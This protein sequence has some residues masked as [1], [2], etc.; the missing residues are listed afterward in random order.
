MTWLRYWVVL[1]AVHM[2]E[3]V[4]DPL[5]DFPW[6]SP[7]QM[8]LPCLVHGP[9]SEQW[10]QSDFH[11]DHLPTVQEASPEDR[12]AGVADGGNVATKSGQIHARGTNYEKQV[13]IMR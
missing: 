12:R 7:C 2:V 3:L 9:N 8:C 13:V 6:L 5:V 11:T 10:C 4:V 1:A